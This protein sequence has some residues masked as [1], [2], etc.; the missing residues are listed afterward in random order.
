MKKKTL[1]REAFREIRN[2][3][4]RFFSILAIVAIGSGFFS[5]VKAA[6]PD[7]KLT[8]QQF[9]SEQ[10]LAD[11][12]L[13]S[14]WGFDEDDL[15]AVTGTE[16]VAVAEGG[17][18]ADF[19][20]DAPSGE[21]QVIKVIGYSADQT[22]NRPLLHAGRLPETSGECVVGSN[23][24]GDDEYWQIG[25]TIT[26]RGDEEDAGDTLSTTS[27]TVVGVVQLPQYFS[28]SYGTS[29][30]SD[31]TLDGFILVPEEDFTLDVYTDVYLTLSSTEG[32]NPFEDRYEQQVD[33]AVDR[34]ETIA[35]ARAETR[36]TDTVDE[37]EAEIADGEKEVA[38]GEQKLA[39][40]EKELQDARQELDDGWAEY[41]DGKAEAEQ[42]FADAEK[43]IADGEAQLKDGE[44][45]WQQNYADYQTALQ[46]LQDSR[47]QLDQYRQQAQELET[48][49][50]ESQAAIQ[51]G[52]Q[53]LSGLQNI[54]SAYSTVTLSDISQADEATQAV[55]ASSSALDE[56][57]PQLLTGYITSSG[58]EKEA[59][60]QSLSGVISNAQTTMAE[61][62]ALYEQ[63][64][65]SLAQLQEALT[66]GEA[67]YEAGSQQLADAKAQLDSG[68][69]TL[70]DKQAQLNS[71]RQELSDARAE[72]DTE[73][74]DALQKLNDGETEYADGYA[75]YQSEKADAETELQD[76]RQEIADARQELDDLQ[77]PEWYVLDRSSFPGVSSISDDADKVDAIAAVFPVFFVLVAALVCLTTMTRMVEEERT[78]IGTLKALGF[79]R[80]AVMFKFLLYAILASI[81]GGVLGSIIGLKLLPYVII[82]CYSAMYQ[83]PF[84]LAPIRWGYLIGCTAVSVVCTSGVTI[85][86]C[87]GVMNT[88]P[89][90][91]M[92]PKAPKNGKRIL[93]ERVGFF[94]KRLN[95][96][97]KVTCRNLF[98]YKSRLMMTVIGVAGCTALMLTG[99]GLRYAISSI[100]TLQYG[101]IFTYSGSL[102]LEDNLSPERTAEVEE[103][104]SGMN[105]VTGIEGLFTKSVDAEANGTTVTEV[106]LYVPSDPSNLDPFIKLRDG[107]TEEPLTLSDEGCIITK[108][109]SR[110]LGVKVGDSI[111]LGSENG[112]MVSVPVTGITEG[113]V[114]HYV[115]LTP[116]TYESLF[117]EEPTPASILFTIG[118]N[119]NEASVNSALLKLS[120][121]QGV[122]DRSF[123]SDAFD[124]LVSSLNMIVWV[125]IGAAAALA[126]IVLYNLSNINVSERVRELATIKVLGFY[127]REVTGYI[128]RENTIAA[129]MGMVAGLVVGIWFEDFVVSTAEVDVVL[130]V[131]GLPASAFIL[132]ALLT[133]VF[134]MAVN[135]IVHFSLKK[136]DMVES[137]K[138]VE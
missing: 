85:A 137:L 124:D 76:A 39:D 7:M 16:D 17:Y 2:S 83:V 74:A 71:A 108:K 21:E 67:E 80:G 33:D 95:F 116:G 29:T 104:V 5:G 58:S 59:Y 128:C 55:I 61:N 133:I 103:E 84:I 102:S 70:D 77:K 18:A 98:R 130:F 9:F 88:V 75:E 118:E 138:S 132:S 24:L 73:L 40:A 115:Y 42:K 64:T 89:A 62:E 10:N 127:D 43:E 52:N 4:S 15:S 63:G 50:S 110:L 87:Y 25:D 30:I 31:G 82:N 96:S 34:L 20:A 19:L 44:A 35:D 135:V 13:M 123:Y 22:L 8:A 65:E 27:F 125:L 92:R 126:V 90:Q 120:G 131:H 41:E 48:T 51:S 68:R 97:G 121:V 12:H 91:L 134:I 46:Q 105:G 3:S 45:Q 93:L 113:Y 47:T 100:S 6:C 11:I 69:A 119:E 57:L 101:E 111:S 72:T 112:E 129:L 32:L 106:N 38:D 86:T 14:T 36:Y 54:Q 1:L 78:Q 122:V 37:A 66:S 56:S 94:W 107:N 81:I 60:G 23:S 114:L 26:V 99:F 117:G 53:L 109:L 28:F 49:L 136:I 79:T